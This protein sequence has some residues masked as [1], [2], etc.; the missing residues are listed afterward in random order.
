MPFLKIVEVEVNLKK[1]S[2]VLQ[3]EQKDAI[4]SGLVLVNLFDLICTSCTFWMW[5]GGG[6]EIL[7]LN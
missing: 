2:K 7:L 3:S 4:K 1:T 5:G 6:K